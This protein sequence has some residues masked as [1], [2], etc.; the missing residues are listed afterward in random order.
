MRKF[1][2]T[3]VLITFLASSLFGCASIVSKSNWPVNVQSNPSGAKCVV[4]K[5]SG[6]QLHSGE[7]PMTVTLD[8]SSGFFSSAKYIVTCNKDG[9]QPSISQLS[10]G[11]NGWYFGNIIFGGL[12]GL[13]IVD[14]AT[15]AMWKLDESHIVNLSTNTDSTIAETEYNETPFIANKSKV[16]PKDIE[17]SIP[18]KSSLKDIRTK[19]ELD[20]IPSNWPQMY[21]YETEEYRYWTISGDI[22]NDQTQAVLSSKSKAD[23]IVKSEYSANNMETTKYTTTH[24]ELVKFDGKFRSWRIIQISKSGG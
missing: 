22:S 24:M 10:A 16:T 5:E 19:N 6:T 4:A 15:G 17:N 3:I 9:Y 23:I 18:K 14:P 13:L 20:Q 8:S 11:M 7:T 21:Y 2:C 1:I 12:I